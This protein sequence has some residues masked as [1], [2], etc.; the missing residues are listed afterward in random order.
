MFAEKK[1]SL[2][3]C[4]VRVVADLGRGGPWPPGLPGLKNL[5]KIMQRSAEIDQSGGALEEELGVSLPPKSDTLNFGFGPPWEN[6][7]IRP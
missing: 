7:L 1:I 5:F 2:S 6:S 3:S 4:I